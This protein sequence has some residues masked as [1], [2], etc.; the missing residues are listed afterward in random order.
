MRRRTS[1]RS[2]RPRGSRKPAGPPPPQSDER[3]FTSPEGR[4][5]ASTDASGWGDPH[6]GG[7][8]SLAGDPPLKGREL[9]RAQQ[10]D[11]LVALEKIEQLAQRLAAR[12]LQIRIARQREHR[13]LAGRLEQGPVHL[14]ARHAKSGHAALPGAEHVAFAAQPQVLLGDAK[15]VLGVAQ[16]REPRLRGLAERRL[17]EQEAS[18]SPRAAADAAAQLVQLREP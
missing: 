6:P 17:V 14:E 13:V 8:L 10:P 15:T 3:A 2:P 7:S 16:D 12:R 4:S 9:P 18:R 11:R 5:R 1:R